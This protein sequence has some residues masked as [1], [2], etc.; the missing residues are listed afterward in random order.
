MTSGVAASQVV[1]DDEDEALEEIYRR[2]W[3]DG[4]PVVVPTESRVGRFLAASE[5]TPEELVGRVPP[6][7]GLATMETIAINCVMAG[8]RPEYLPVVLAALR[9]MLADT[10]NLNGVQTTTNCVAPLTIV[11][12]QVVEELGF[13][14]GDGV[15]GGGSRA[16]AS[17]GRALR[18]ILWNVGGAHPG[19]LDRA[20]IGH[21]GKY[22]YCIAENQAA[23]P[24]ESLH[25]ERGLAADASAVTVFACEAPH[26]VRT[27][28]AESGHV[29]LTY[30]ADAIPTLGNSV[31]A[32][33][34]EMLVVVGPRAAALLAGEGWSKADVR[35]YL[36][37][38]ARVPVEL[39]RQVQ[40]PPGGGVGTES[41]RWPRWIDRDDGRARL[42]A[43]RRPE[44]AILVVA[45][46]WGGSY[47]F[48]AVA[49]GWNSHGSFATTVAIE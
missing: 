6:R 41:V 49:P 27:G 2:G 26:H 38:N 33:G 23:S 31:T 9:A 37:E 40:P 34:G 5:G 43:L 19:D 16:S 17:V 11:S 44:D 24:W 7:M 21:P 22:G 45:G 4:L 15:F 30:L 25:V 39:L 3:T 18:L 12:G 47:A 14:C 36:C 42:R 35:A 48:C 29:A 28:P 10:F 8:C 1:L 20:T 46:G 13:H 32:G